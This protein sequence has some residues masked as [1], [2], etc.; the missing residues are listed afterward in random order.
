MAPMG[1]GC[2]WKIFTRNRGKSGMEGV[3]FIMGDGKFLLSLH[4][5]QKGSNPLFMKT[6]YCLLLPPFSNFVQILSPLLFLTSTPTALSVVLFLW[7]NGWSCHIWCAILLSDNMF[8]ATRHHVYWGLTYVVFYW[9]SDITNKQ[10]CS[11]HWG[12]SGLTY[13]YKCIFIPPVMCS[14][15]LPLLY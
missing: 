15:Q 2:V 12:A 3:G 13:P 4:S 11:T 1:G 10:T 8:Y 14:K 7:L 9:Y 6:L 5:W